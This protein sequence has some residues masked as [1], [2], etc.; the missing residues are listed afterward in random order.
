MVYESKVPIG[1]TP[2]YMAGHYMLQVGAAQSGR[3]TLQIGAGH[4]VRQG[5]GMKACWA[6]CTR[7][8]VGSVRGRSTAARQ[9]RPDSGSA[10]VS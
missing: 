5:N 2:E 3:A 8:S 1:A 10:P 7:G 4:G 6:K 9:A